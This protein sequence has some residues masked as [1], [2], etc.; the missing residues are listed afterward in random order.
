[1]QPVW[2]IHLG[3]TCHWSAEKEHMNPPLKCHMGLTYLNVTMFGSKL[4][5]SRYSYNS[6]SLECKPGFRCVTFVAARGQY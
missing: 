5:W 3:I 6:K 1:M 2:A 4:N